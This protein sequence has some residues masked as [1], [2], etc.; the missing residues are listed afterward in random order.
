MNIYIYIHTYM[1]GSKTLNVE[2]PSTCIKETK[3]TPTC[4]YG[5]GIVQGAT[6]PSLDLIKLFAA[7]WRALVDAHMS[8]TPHT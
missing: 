1:Y 2:C 7:P 6:A 8:K 4:L 3:H 5:T